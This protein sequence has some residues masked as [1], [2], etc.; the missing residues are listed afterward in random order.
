MSVVAM[1]STE[2]LEEKMFKQADQ[3][4]VLKIQKMSLEKEKMA[5]RGFID[6]Y[7][8]ELF[9]MEKACDDMYDENRVLKK[10]L[11]KHREECRRLKRENFLLKQQIEDLED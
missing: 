10:K 9:N 1:D 4:S 8:E 7:K 2:A 6:D 11:E 3:I 5:L